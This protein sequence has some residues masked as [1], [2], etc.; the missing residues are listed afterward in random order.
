MA[1]KFL[2]AVTGHMG[3]APNIGIFRI[4]TVFLDC[5]VL[6]HLINMCIP[7]FAKIMSPL[8]Q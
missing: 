1:S 7:G 2:M 4:F 5:K 8:A 6:D 3:F